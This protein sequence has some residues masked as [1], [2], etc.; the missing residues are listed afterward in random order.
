LNCKPEQSAC[1]LLLQ[2]TATR[3]EL[4]KIRGEL[5]LPVNPRQYASNPKIHTLRIEEERNSEIAFL[6]SG[7]YWNGSLTR[8]FV[9]RAISHII[10]FRSSS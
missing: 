5:N 7:I 3:I 1:G 9:R 2:E 4:P 8:A 6:F 10:T